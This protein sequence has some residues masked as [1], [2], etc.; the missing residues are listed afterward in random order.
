MAMV[1]GLQ[2]MVH[3]QSLPLILS[4]L[5]F[6]GC[7]RTAPELHTN[8]DAGAVV[9]APP[10]VTSEDVRV[11][12]DGAD[13][14]EAGVRASL[15][16]TTT[17]AVPD[18]TV[19]RPR[20]PILG[21]IPPYGPAGSCDAGAGV[22]CGTFPNGI[23]L[24]NAPH[25]RKTLLEGN[26]DGGYR[27]V[28]ATLASGLDA[29]TTPPLPGNGTATSPITLAKCDAG[30]FEGLGTDAGTPA[31]R[32]VAATALSGLVPIANGGTGAAMSCASGKVPIAQSSTALQCEAI[33]GGLH[34]LLVGRRHVHAGARRSIGRRR[35]LRIVA[36]DHHTRRLQSGYHHV[37]DRRD[38]RR[39]RRDHGG[40]WHEHQRIDSTDSR[41][42]RIWG[43]GR[44]VYR[45]RRG[46]AQHR[47]H[48]PQCERRCDE[49]VAARERYM[50]H[51][52]ALWR[53]G[54][55]RHGWAAPSVRLVGLERGE[56]RDDLRQRRCRVVGRC[57]G[58]WALAGEKG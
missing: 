38:Q 18:A 52:D 45:V 55:L 36:R 22:A 58:A 32:P 49:R 39:Q 50:H 16:A 2:H 10:E 1:F 20:P 53:G 51:G 33:S 56:L 29:A 9:D 11:G 40:V 14:M 57:D 3:R 19:I 47:R 35:Q 6:V 25:G 13:A 26:G 4:L 15:D 21:E 24:A 43:S 48:G 30:E 28:D 54:H 42:R 17:H 37:N 44:G 27:F 34:D 8:G 5:A 41:Y 31:C 7:A 23:K 46:W 12:D